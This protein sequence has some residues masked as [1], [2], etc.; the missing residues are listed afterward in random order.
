MLDHRRRL[1]WSS[2]GVVL[3]GGRF[4]GDAVF[5][6]PGVFTQVVTWDEL[7]RV[8]TLDPW[9]AISLTAQYARGRFNEY[10]LRRT[11]KDGEGFGSHIE[12]FLEELRS[13]KARVLSGE[14]WLSRPVVRW[15]T[16]AHMPGERVPATASPYRSSA[17]DCSPVVARRAPL[18]WTRR[19]RAP[20][21]ATNGVAGAYMGFHLMTAVGLEFTGLLPL[22]GASLGLGATASTVTAALLTRQVARMPYEIRDAYVALTRDHLYARTSWRRVYRMPVAELAA[23]IDDSKRN[24]SRYIFGRRAALILSR[25]PGCPLISSLDALLA[26]RQS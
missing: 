5:D 12:R 21:V 7:T 24:T 19:A 13:R 3:N 26:Q 15:Q 17:A 22:L 23:R 25:V 1:C 10:Q 4:A 14:G 6:N 8:E 2:R 16:T 9:P 20:V 11:A 18:G